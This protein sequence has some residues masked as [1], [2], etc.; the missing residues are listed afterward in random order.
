MRKENPNP[1]HKESFLDTDEKMFSKQFVDALS[2]I[3]FD[4]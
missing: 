3:F 1:L 2:L 4:E